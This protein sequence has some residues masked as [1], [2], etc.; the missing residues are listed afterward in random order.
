VRANAVFQLLVQRGAADAAPARQLFDAAGEGLARLVERIERMKGVTA[1]GH[2]WGTSEQVEGRAPAPVAAWRF[3][4]PGQ[5]TGGAPMK[6]NEDGTLS[7]SAATLTTAGVEDLL[8]ELAEARSN[9]DPPVPHMAPEGILAVQEK[10]GLRASFLMNGTFALS[11]RHE[12]FG[13]LHFVLSEQDAAALQAY[14]AVNVR[15]GNE[16]LVH[17]DKDGQI[18]GH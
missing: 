16:Q 10:T 7:L 12:G 2:G 11:L 1:V 17:N 18:T 6:L 13:W 9:M 4:Q 8:K 14:I 3:Q 15:T 5:T